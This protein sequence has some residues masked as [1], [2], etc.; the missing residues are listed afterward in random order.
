[1]RRRACVVLLW[2]AAVAHE[3]VAQHHGRGV[4]DS[5]GGADPARAA[6]LSI[7]PLP[8]D[9]GNFYT[10][11]WRRGVL[12]TTAE[13][14]LL[15]PAGVLLQRNGWMAGMHGYPDYAA[16]ANRRSWTSTE[17]SQ[18][19]SLMAGY[20][21]V[22]LIAAFDAGKTAER[23]HRRLALGYDATARAAVLA[24]AAPFAPR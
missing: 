8:V 14:V 3:G 20:V 10:G 4:V 9:L 5:L 11:S 18:F 21:V 12:Y 6:L 13:L 17:R 24:V 19:T 22:K 1:M 7:Q 16:T 23:H 15:V 2:L